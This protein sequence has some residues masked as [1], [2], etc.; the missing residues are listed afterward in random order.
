MNWHPHTETPDGLLTAVIAVESME[1]DDRP[2]IAGEIYE[3]RPEH[4]CWMGETNGLT[5]KH[6]VFWWMPERELLETLP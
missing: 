4:E 5:L 6:P 1:S 2:Y 3:W